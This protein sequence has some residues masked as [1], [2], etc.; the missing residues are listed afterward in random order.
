MQH[1]TSTTDIKA[2]VGY[3]EAYIAKMRS[4]PRLTTREINK[5]RRATLLLNKLKKKLSS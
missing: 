1:S 2:I 4:E 5:V 3:L